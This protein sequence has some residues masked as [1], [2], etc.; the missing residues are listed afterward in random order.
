MNGSRGPVA[1]PD[2]EPDVAPFPFPHSFAVFALLLYSNQTVLVRAPFF[3]FSLPSTVVFFS[4]LKSFF[5]TFL[6]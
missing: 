6:V 4:F 2:V 5:R 1:D 3:V